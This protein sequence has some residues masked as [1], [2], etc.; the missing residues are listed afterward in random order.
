MVPLVLL[1]VL[2]VTDPPQLAMAVGLSKMSLLSSLIELLEQTPIVFA[3][4]NELATL[5]VLAL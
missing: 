3:V 5:T 1:V 2:V 4:I